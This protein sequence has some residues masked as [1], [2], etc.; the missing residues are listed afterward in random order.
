MGGESNG[1]GTRSQPP[2]DPRDGLRPGNRSHPLQITGGGVPPPPNPDGGGLECSTAGMA[3]RNGGRHRQP[4][5]RLVCGNTG[6]YHSA[7]PECG[8][9][10]S[11]PAIPSHGPTK[12]GPPPDS[13]GGGPGEDGGIHPIPSQGDAVPAA[14]E[15]LG[16]RAFL[17]ACRSLR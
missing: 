3:G 15:E 8:S 14:D 1:P 9:E 12:D 16:W 17:T 6:K 7:F 5:K 2:V 10:E 11:S 13:T 4:L